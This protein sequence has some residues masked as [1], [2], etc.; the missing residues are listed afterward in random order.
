MWA[1]QPGHLRT[2][3]LPRGPARHRVAR[4]T[5]HASLFGD[6]ETTSVRR[7]RSQRKRCSSQPAR[8]DPRTGPGPC[9]AMAHP[10]QITTS[11]GCVDRDP[12]HPRGGDRLLGQCAPRCATRPRRRA[13]DARGAA[14]LRS[15]SPVVNGGRA[16]HARLRVFWSMAP[17]AGGR[18]RSAAEDP[19]PRARAER[20]ARPG[21]RRARRPAARVLHHRWRARPKQRGYRSAGLG[22]PGRDHRLRLRRSRGEARLSDTEGLPGVVSRVREVTSRPGI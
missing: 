3:P 5:R 6:G 16:E 14:A 4:H 22:H 17:R 8:I 2:Q 21:D 11:H 7:V 12:R 10:V 19:G 20:R 13:A 18:R 1:G 9:R 15:R